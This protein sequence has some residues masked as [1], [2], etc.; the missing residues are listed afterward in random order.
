M[1][2]EKNIQQ[3]KN[4]GLSE[5]E[6][7]RQINI[8]KEGIPFA[9]VMAA[10][11]ANNGIEVFSEKQQQHFVNLFEVE[12]DKLELLKF[13]PASGAATRMFKF[14]HEFLEKYNPAENIDEFLQKEENLNAKLFFESID[15]FAFSFLVNRKLKEKY[16]DFENF[17]KEKRYYLF[18]KE[19]LEE[20]GLNFSNTPKGLVPFH[21]YGDNYVTAFGEQLYEAAFYVTSNG[22]ANLHFTVSA[23]HE[24]KFKKRFEEV[25]HKV[26]K[27]TGVQ[28]KISY[29]FQKQ[30]TD[31]V[32]V[33]SKNNLFIDEN[34]DLLFRPSGHGALL[35]NL[36][37]VDADII[38]IKNIDNVVSRNY[39]E[40]VAFQK[41][42]LAGKL[43]LLQQK[44]FRFIEQLQTENPSEALLKEIVKF[45]SEELNIKD[46]PIYKKEILK[47]LDRPIRVCGVV[48]NTGAPGGGPF[49]IKDKDGNLSY[50]IVEMSQIDTNNSKQKAL[51]EEATHFNPVDLVCGVRNYKGEKYNLLKYSDPDAG[52]ISNKS[53]QG[54]PIKALELPGLWNGA[55]ANWNTVFVEVP[56]ITFNP[57]KTVNDLLN[58]VH[59]PK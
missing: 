34:G 55:M 30:E 31:T 13:V 59:Q 17:N 24:E 45:I 40:T 35:E 14:L 50:Q 10:A 29:S 3:I 51:V 53:Y 5:A 23:E 48:E 6:V 1:F 56:L 8:F 4:H 47:I 54:K 36:N 43:I 32:A 2:T 46:T 26:E 11:S 44:I 9:N 37:D 58:E 15:D 28:L 20:D 49:L 22:I 41:K 38:F 18:V 19:I 12:K 25:E 52:F 39:V 33:T 21:K 16:P 27:K 57:V 42:V 7:T